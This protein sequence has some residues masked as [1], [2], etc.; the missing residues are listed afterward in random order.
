MPLI[1]TISVVPSRV[2]ISG[3]WMTESRFGGYTITE[4]LVTGKNKIGVDVIGPRELWFGIA[5]CR[6]GKQPIVCRNRRKH[7]LACNRNQRC[8]DCI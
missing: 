7:V 3:R 8:L 4:E 2:G 5:L 1:R 6:R